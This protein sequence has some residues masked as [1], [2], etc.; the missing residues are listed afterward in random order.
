MDERRAAALRILDAALRAADPRAAVLRA[1]AIDGTRLRVADQ[2]EI[3]LKVVDRVLLVG[4]GKA[5]VGMARGALEVFGG[6]IAEGSLTTRHGGGADLPGI[7]VWEA[8]HPVP[9]TGGLAGAADAL[10]L[11]RAAG[12]RDLVLCLLSGGASALWPAPVAGVSLSDLQR[13]TER[14]V[15][16]GAPIAEINCVR[17]HLSRIAG[18]RLAQAAAP[19]RI[20]TL[21]IS[22]VV[23]GALD[24]IGSG[25]TVPD[26][27]TYE[28]ALEVLDRWEVD[29]PASVLAHLR[30]GDAGQIADTP[31]DFDPAF[32]RASAYV[33]ASNADALRAAAD[34]AARL[35]WD[36]RVVADDVEGD[37]RSVGEQVARLGLET[38]AER[39][40][41]PIALLL[42]GETT[43]AVK[44]GGR[45]GRNQEL[46]LGAALE[47]SGESGILVASAATDGVDGPTDAAGGFA[48][49]GTVARGEAAGL[50]A[51]DALRRNDAYPFL[52]A[53]GDLIVTGPTGTNVNDIIVVLVDPASPD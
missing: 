4:A 3:D 45:G 7:E 33:I 6:W 11:A 26:P 44:G 43:V 48:D 24:A 28:D 22:D 52:R 8:A 42:G 2:E 1:L 16:C 15:R 17:K 23:G 38:R 51:D 40:P 30:R 31:D 18:G 27:T 21:A 29:A 19:A 20:V 5:A 13:V 47:L 37:A 46:A 35:G 36:A 49:G 41:R 10:R 9:D 25:P 12:P 32:A 14:L 53:A 39:S 34:E 50:D